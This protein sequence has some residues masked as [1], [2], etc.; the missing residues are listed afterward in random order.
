MSGRVASILP[1][2][3]YALV[4]VA[5]LFAFVLTPPEA[6]MGQVVRLLYFHVGAAWNA[7]LAFGAVLLASVA[8][9]RSRAPRW[10]RWAAASAEVGVV[11]TTVTLISGSF[12]ARAV[13]NTWWRWEPRLTSTLL[14]WFIY[15]AYLLVRESIDE[16][17]RRG[18]VA[19]VIGI[20]GFVDVPIVYFSS[21]WWSGFHPATA[22]LTGIM[23]AGLM[24]SV[25]AFTALYAHLVWL[26][27]SVRSLEARAG[28]ARARLEGPEP[29]GSPSSDVGRARPGEAT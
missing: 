25:V 22:E 18:V 11:F 3:T 21:R 29:Q 20:V 26:A 10:D 9:L 8:F 16:P 23:V 28:E 12:W 7:F 4:V 5:L 24:A 27:V 15:V 17:E 2:V 14:L 13:W 19:A 1:W 6:T